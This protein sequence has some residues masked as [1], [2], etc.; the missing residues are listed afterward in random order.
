MTLSLGLGDI[1]KNIY[2]DC[3]SKFWLSIQGVLAQTFSTL[4]MLI[5][6]SVTLEMTWKSHFNY[7]ANDL[8]ERQEMEKLSIYL[9]LKTKMKSNLFSIKAKFNKRCILHHILNMTTIWVAI[10]HTFISSLVDPRHLSQLMS[11]LH[12]A[13]WY[14]GINKLSQTELIHG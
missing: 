5:R 10:W 1:A 7:Q 2:L 3:F 9:S 4:K 13:I 11:V 14:R 12:P 6:Q 8:S